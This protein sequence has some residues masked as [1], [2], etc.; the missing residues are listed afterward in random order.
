MRPDSSSQFLTT[1]QQTA[2]RS[3]NRE[4]IQ[5]ADDAALAQAIMAS[6]AELEKQQTQEDTTS[7]DDLIQA[8]ITASLKSSGKASSPADQQKNTEA[9]LDLQ[10]QKTAGLRIWFD[11]HGFDVIPN[12][13]G[14]SNNCFLI[15]LLQH[16]TGDYRSEHAAEVS[17]YRQQLMQWDKTIKANDPLPSSGKLI[18]NLIELVL[19][20]KKCN[21]RFAIAG[22]SLGSEPSWHFYG[23]GK[24]YAIIFDQSGHY[25]A[26]IPRQTKVS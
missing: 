17:H 2:W 4:L 19:K 21:R 20:D 15:S 22:P 9:Y 18:E 24:D 26:V 13:G 6:L 8:A 25:E 16:A 7:E 14:R 11:K 1:S 12:S 23:K 10:A 3:G 5:A